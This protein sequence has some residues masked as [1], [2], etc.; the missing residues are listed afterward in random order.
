MTSLQGAIPI[1]KVDRVTEGVGKHLDLH[2]TWSCEIAFQQERAVC[3]CALSQSPGARERRTDLAGVGDDAHPL[4]ST[5][6]RRLDHQRQFERPRN[7][8]EMVEVLPG[9]FVARQ[10]GHAGRAH[11]GLGD[12]LG[13]HGCHRGRRRPHKDQ[14]GIDTSRSEPGVLR[15]KAVAGMNRSGAGRSRGSQQVPDVQIAFARGRRAN[16]DGSIRLSH[17]LRASIGFGVNGDRAN[18]QTPCRAE[19]PAR[20][21]AAVGDQQSVDQVAHY[22]RKMP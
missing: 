20:N 15:E 22:M 6:C 1:S 18:A 14:S 10:N 21:F 3:E 11:P 4:P 9:P 5:S 12:A 19:D 16:T 8:L 13:R 2:M 7:A 17:V